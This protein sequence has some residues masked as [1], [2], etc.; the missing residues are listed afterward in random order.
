[1]SKP[2]EFAITVKS[3]DPKEK[4][5]PKD[6]PD[7]QGSSKLLKDGKEE[8]GEELVRMSIISDRQSAN[9]IVV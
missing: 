4:E 8:E 1:M 3:D 5:K 2:Q 9:V 6:K 7:L